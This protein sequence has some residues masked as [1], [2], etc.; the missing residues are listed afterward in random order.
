[1]AKHIGIV[2]CSVEGAAL[3]YR[4]VAALAEA[5]LGEHRHPEMSIHTHPL[6]EY[7]R[8]IR[9]GK[10]DAVA[11]L[12]L[13]SAKKLASIGADFIV[14]PDNTIHQAF[15]AVAARSPVPWLHI[16]R[17]VAAEARARGF[18]QIGVLGTK[19]T[20]DGPV[21]REALAGAGL[22]HAVPDREAREKIDDIIFRELVRGKLLQGSRGF[23]VHVIHRL[24]EAGCD[25]VVLGCTE[26][27]L[28][29][30]PK[31][32]PLPVLDSTR[33]LARAAL[34]EAIG[35]GAAAKTVRNVRSTKGGKRR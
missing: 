7:M 23:I 9:A 30:E 32:S 16:A 15:D 11:A 14:C 18:R 33:L 20:C 8:P 24:R 10:W 21:Y 6:A 34:M 4:E 22:G 13:D 5:E 26:I 2:A 35:K 31:D 3:C 28:L 27:P 19:Y 25:A 29:I 1:M 17:V 12:M